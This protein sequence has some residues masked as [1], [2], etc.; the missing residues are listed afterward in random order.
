MNR[1]TCAA[2]LANYHS[3]SA[4]KVT[5]NNRHY[6]LPAWS[7]SILPDCRTDVFNTARVRFQPSQIQMLPSN[8]KLLSWETYD[9]DVS[10]LAE[11]SKITASGL[12][13][14]LS[15]TRDT[16]DYLWYIT[17]IDISP[18]E[19]FLRGRNKPSISVHSSGDAVHV[20][21]NGKFSGTSTK[22]RRFCSAF[23]TKKKPSFN[24]NGPIDLR[25]GT[26][27]IALLSV[28]VGLP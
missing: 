22:M 11:N 1:T 15:A 19:S 10:S 7:I 24:F 20:F 3:N 13:E 27:K 14:Q 4:A 8:S 17:S 25:A 12:L 18:S 26:N 9:E 2:F 28:A 23:G 16:S 5:F 21:I 6:D